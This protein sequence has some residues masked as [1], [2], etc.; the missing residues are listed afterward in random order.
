MIAVAVLAV[1]LWWG[2]ALLRALGV[3]LRGGERIVVGSVLGLAS[4]FW[5]IYLL[6]SAVGELSVGV[7]LSGAGLLGLGAVAARG[8]S[9][10]L[11]GRP[12][13]WWL[14][15]TGAVGLV[16]VAMNLYGVLAT[17]G[18]GD[19]VAVE[20]VW[21]DA[22][23]HASIV[24]SFAHGA[25]YP[26]MYPLALGEPLGY[27]FAVDFVTGA[28]VTGGLG[29]RPAFVVVNVLVQLAFFAGL[30]LLARRVSGSV[31]AAV[32]G[33]AVLFALGNL[34]W[35]AIPA[36]VAEAGGVWSWLRDLPWSYTGDALGD[37]GR[38]RV[39][40][41][42]YLGNPTF[43]YFL[44]R[45]AAAF[46]LAAAMSLLIL[47]D[48]MLDRRHFGTAAAAGI[49]LG[50][51]P[52]IHAHSVIAIL[53]FVG[54]WTFLLPWRRGASPKEWPHVWRRNVWP[55][56][57]AGGIALVVAL[58]QLLEMSRQASGF[59]DW[60][61]GWT[62]EPH[63]LAA[64]GDVLEALWTLGPFWL[65][66]GGLLVPLLVV[67]LVRGPREL[68]YWYVPFAV[69]WV[70]GNVVRAQPWEWDN[71]N[72]FVY[73]QIGTV[74]LVAPFLADLLRRGAG[75]GW[76]AM[77]RPAVGGILVIG[78]T[79]G[80]LLSFIYAAQQRH[81]LWSEGD[82]DVALE[83]R[84]QTPPD[85]VVLTANGHSQPVIALSGRQ[86]Y[87]G[88]SGWFVSHGL[89][90]RTYEER[91]EAMYAGDVGLMREL[92]IDYV[93]LGPW[94]RGFAEARDFRLGGVFADEE[95]FE[96]VFSRMVDGREWRLVEL[97]PATPGSSG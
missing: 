28:L 16:L 91:L 26:P 5:V 4:G 31:K 78:L 29:L 30:A 73:W 94:E 45:R 7:L 14:W 87:M 8:R 50:L 47:F 72:F 13:R 33:T 20:H 15:T 60:W 68:R 61:F 92:G 54:A 46:G 77:I 21:A 85:A 79:L 44:P 67:A 34:G 55:W 74:V 59:V 36:D 37:K 66:N 90:W 1:S 12:E 39:G 48:H 69:L 62:G 19:V 75:A 3:D 49:L 81:H 89:D 80:G 35:L 23:F 70:F 53:A 10:L 83:V 32:V 58:P 40:M 86:T 22:P 96:E 11:G 97:D 82:V 18:E 6:A 24:T 27:P 65:L 9:A 51:L 41:G 63:D 43:I 25:N 2:F 88:F 93:V 71:N 57:L 52:R 95:I 42:V 56:A 84:E 76:R 38:D 64:A 17:T